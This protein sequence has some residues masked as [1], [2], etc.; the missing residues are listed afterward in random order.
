MDNKF[1]E[2]SDLAKMLFGYNDPCPFDTAA[3]YG[4]A[5]LCI[6]GAD[7]EV[8]KEE[9]DWLTKFYAYTMG[10]P[11]DLVDA[12]KSFDY[13]KAKLETILEKLE[14]VPVNFARALIYDAIRMSK[15]D[16]EYAQKERK[17]VF[18][19]A[20][21]LGVDKVIVAQLECLVENEITMRNHVALL[22]ETPGYKI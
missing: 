2:F 7:G 3:H 12:W 10:A 5:L 1:I 17:S 22:L 9:M 11:K 21:I 14:G 19:A 13:K 18:K 20:G 6:A 4:Y 8:S 15:A 16:K